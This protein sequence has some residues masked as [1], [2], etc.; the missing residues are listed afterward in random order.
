VGDDVSAVRDLAQVAGLAGDAGLALT[1]AAAVVGWDGEGVPGYEPGAVDLDAAAA[2]GEHLERAAGRLRAARGILGALEPGELVWPVG[3]AVERARTEISRSARLAT[4]A[5]DVAA[6]L[7]GMLGGQGERSY[8][9]VMM[10]PSDPRGSGGYPGTYGVLRAVDGRIELTELAPTSTLGRVDPVEPPRPDVRR[11]ARFGAL[12]HFISATY[13]PDWPTSA[14]LF[15]RMWEASGREPM[16][17]AIGADP[18]FLSHLLAAAGPVSTEAW[19]EEIAAGNVVRILGRDTFVTEDA[20]ESNRWQVEI[21]NA[22][23]SAV[24][25]RP[26]EPEPL[27]SGLGSSVA[28]RHLQVY[29]RDEEDQALLRELDAAGEVDLGPNDVLVTTSGTTSNRAGFFAETSVEL[30]REALAGGSEEHVVTIAIENDAPEGPE[31]ILLG[32]AT[33]D[34]GVG[35]YAALV[36][37]YLPARATRI[38]SDV[39]GELGLQLVEEELGRPVVL[40]AVEVPP[41]TRATVTVRYEPRPAGVLGEVI[42]PIE[43]PD[44]ICGA[45]QVPD[46][47]GEGAALGEEPAPW[48]K[49]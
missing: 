8:L 25:T 18:V 38:R 9:L 23:W 10:N 20:E 27:L 45:C 29:V 40:Q 49:R 36:N 7:P 1:D 4:R 43:G 33:D 14:E 34:Y 22:L 47:A 37:V 16:D 11:Y 46:G 35:T 2:A 15:L 48:R 39:D 42:P 6:L 30:V 17:G 24:L 28:E 13:P 41:G 44:A 31:S 3:D 26:L 19:P 12:T 5:E 21:G 32:F